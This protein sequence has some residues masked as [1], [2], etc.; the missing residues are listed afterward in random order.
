MTL[1]E[2][3]QALGAYYRQHSAKIDSA[4]L[5]GFDSRPTYSPVYGI[6]D[7]YV[8][9][10]KHLEKALQPHMRGFTPHGEKMRFLPE[11]HQVRR[12]KINF[13]IDSD[14][15]VRL[16]KSALS[17]LVAGVGSNPTVQARSVAQLVLNSLL[18]RADEELEMDVH[19]KGVYVEPTFPTPGEP[20]DSINGLEKKVDDA[21]DAGKVIPFALGD[22]AAS[23]T[24]DYVEEMVG[25]LPDRLK[26]RAN[27]QIET[28]MSNVENYWENRRTKHGAIM[29]Y[30]GNKPLTVKNYSNIT[31]K[32]IPGMA[33][34]K[35]F[36]VT[37]PGN[38]ISMWGSA[39]EE[40]A[41]TITPKPDEQVLRISAFFKMAVG[42]RSFG[43]PYTGKIENQ[44]VYINDVA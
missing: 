22:F 34:S 7:Q 5:Q 15:I 4:L 13:E 20:G 1:E 29:D 2:L 41:M 14:D 11:V 17:P 43:V 3:N 30:D 44:L 23:E 24:L 18:D 37:V 35:R 6:Q 33:D 38:K 32:G 36:I 21:R 28:S 26:K 39:G 31:L 8:T 42:Y 9:N 12:V 16:E 25:L 19:Y 40:R 27:L 10:T